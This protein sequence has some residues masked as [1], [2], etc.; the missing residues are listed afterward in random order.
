MT[1]S[2]PVPAQ[3]ISFAVVLC[4][5]DYHSISS[6]PPR[7]LVSIHTSSRHTLLCISRSEECWLQTTQS[8]KL[9]QP[10]SSAGA[11]S[12][13]GAS[14]KPPQP[15]SAAASLSEVPLP[16]TC[17]PPNPSSSEVSFSGFGGSAT[18]TMQAWNPFRPRAGWTMNETGV[19]GSWDGALVSMLDTPWR[20]QEVEKKV[21]E[22]LLCHRLRRDLRSRTYENSTCELSASC[23]LFRLI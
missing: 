5:H 8:P 3:M 18:L 22:D 15:S 1:S 14:P 21:S 12:C 13:A 10:T 23:D 16:L 6:D 7:K 19:S 4:S 17:N 2:D 11:A 20:W 9:P